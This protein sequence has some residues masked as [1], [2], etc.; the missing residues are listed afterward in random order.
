VQSQAKDSHVTY[1]YPK[2][3]SGFRSY[4]ILVLFYRRIVPFHGAQLGT[5]TIHWALFGTTVQLRCR[6]R[7]YRQYSAVDRSVNGDDGLV[8]SVYGFPPAL[9]D[10]T[11]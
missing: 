2:R 6:S 5:K 3:V 8:C 11:T 10:D 1:V 7:I 4:Q 9:D